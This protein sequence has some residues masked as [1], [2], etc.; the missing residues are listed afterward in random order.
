MV[1]VHFG[2]PS[3]AGSKRTESIRTEQSQ[4]GECQNGLERRLLE[5]VRWT[6]STG[7][8]LPQQSESILAH[9]LQK[10]LTEALSSESTSLSLLEIQPCTLKTEHCD[11]DAIMRRQQ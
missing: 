8:A 9:H 2:P 11:Y 4:D 3:L 6:V 5:T 7:V 10:R 1:R